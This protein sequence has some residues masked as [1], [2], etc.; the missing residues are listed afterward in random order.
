MNKYVILLILALALAAMSCSRREASDARKLSLTVSIEPQ[1]AILEEIA[2]NRAEVVT[3]LRGG[4]DPETYEPT[5]A[6]MMR[7]ERNDAYFMIGNVDFEKQLSNRLTP[8]AVSR[9]VNCSEG[10]VPVKDTHS[11]AHHHDDGDD[12]HEEEGAEQPDPHTWSSVRNL[13]VMAGNMLATLCR[14]DPEGEPY[15]TERYDR[16][17]NRLDSLDSSWSAELAPLKG[18]SFMMWHPA[19]SYFARDYNLGQHSVSA[20]H[21]ETTP[22]KLHEI[23]SM[24]GHDDRPLV[25]FTARGLDPRVAATVTSQL[26][27]PVVEFDPLDYN[28][29][30]SLEKVVETLKLNNPSTHEPR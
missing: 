1:R 11:H 5:F 27:I 20:Q 24:S 16:L 22:A 6:S 12:D 17:V 13:R 2:G 3:L 15:Y 26:D 10:I 4:A 29:Q 23:L 8:E 18:K 7:L 9:M 25:F 30:T 19:L 14:L 21:K 28:W